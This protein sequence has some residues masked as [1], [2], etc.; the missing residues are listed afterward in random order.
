MIQ[1]GLI[2]YEEEI[3]L[4]TEKEIEQKTENLIKSALKE[5]NTKNEQ[6]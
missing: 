6:N 3:I 4:K 1:T 5:L 2:Y